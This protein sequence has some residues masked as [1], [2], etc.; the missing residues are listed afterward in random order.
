MRRGA[1]PHDLWAERHEPV[2]AIVRD[3]IECDMD[4][5]GCILH[6]A[7][8]RALRT[9]LRQKQAYSTIGMRAHCGYALF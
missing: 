8:I 1:Q 5:H 6:R 7:P 2:V 3:V 4:G 9:K